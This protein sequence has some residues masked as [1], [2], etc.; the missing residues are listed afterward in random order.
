M[1]CGLKAIAALLLIFACA[2]VVSSP[3]YADSW[4]ALGKRTY[5]SAN[6]AWRLVVTP[7]APGD[8]PAGRGPSEGRLER[9]GPGR[10]WTVQW[11]RTLVNE[12]APAGALVSDDGRH[13]V[14]FDNW[15]SM[16]HGD[17]VVVIYDGAGTLIRSFRLVDLVPADYVEALP[18]TV[19]SILWSGG[20]HRLSAA[21][22]SL[23]LEVATPSERMYDGP[24]PVPIEVVLATGRP[25]PPAGPAWER[26]LAATARVR[27]VQREARARERTFMTEPLL[28]PAG[29]SRQQWD[30]YLYEAFSRLDPH[31]E[32]GN[33]SIGA[34]AAPGDPDY[35]TFLPFVTIALSGPPEPGR[36]VLFASPD[37]ENLARVLAERVAHM[38]PGRL[39]GV[40]VYVAAHDALWPRV[41]ALFAPTGAELIQLD[42]TEPIPQRPERLRAYIAGSPT[43]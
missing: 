27:A 28:G 22:D 40:R 10:R 9:R 38:R 3:A 36:I 1:R 29:G 19:G 15:Y 23:L 37:E 25:V 39:R 42:P 8:P 31:W 7:A 14:T 20:Q 4:V 34:L 21:G 26:A 2:C 30:A 17:N 13:A 18:H 32:D 16:G 5:T 43:P 12:L 24:G 6:G 35:E 41:A 33:A 11:R